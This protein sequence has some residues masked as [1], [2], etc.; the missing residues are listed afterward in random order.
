MI[1]DLSIGFNEID[2]FLIRYHELKDVVDLFVICEATH[3]HSGKQ[4]PLYFSEWL[5]T[6]PEGI[7]P[8][9]IEIIT[10]DNG[11]DFAPLT[12]DYAWVR[13]NYQREILG[14]WVTKNLQS[15]DI[16]LLSDMDEIPS[17]ASLQ[18]FLKNVDP[19]G[20]WRFDQVLSYFYFN[21]TAG[22]WGGT[23]LFKACVLNTTRTDKP[24]TDEIRYRPQAQIAGIIPG[25]FH[26]SSCGGLENVR[27]KFDSYAHT[28]MQTEQPNE[29][30]ADSMNRLVDPFH[31]TP[32]TIVPID[33]LPEYVQQNIDYFTRKGYICH[34]Q[35]KEVRTS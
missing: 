8:Y 5:Q 30:I 17:G 32:L 12:N 11:A 27:T 34:T 28:E 23:K 15:D 25:G 29:R 2:L 20:V 35:Q 14:Q 10:W 3:T 18:T 6:A 7:N 13:E 22:G 16:C 1:V 19:S 24:M 33:T 31:G 4:K 9:Q 26:F 21:T